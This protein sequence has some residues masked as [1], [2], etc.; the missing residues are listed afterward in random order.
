M[1]ARITHPNL[2]KVYSAGHDAGW[3]YLAMELVDGS[4]VSEMLAARKRFDER[5]ALEVTLGVARA[6][7][8]AERHAI[9]HR[10]VKPANILLKA[11][12]T[13]KLTDLGLAKDRSADPA[14]GLTTVGFCV[15]TTDYL[16][17]E[18][19]GLEGWGTWEPD[20]RGDVF[21]LGLTLYEMLTGE[22]PLKAP[23]P[24]KTLLRHSEEDVPPPS[25]E[26]EE[27]APTTDEIVL[28]M[29]ARHPPERYQS[30][31]E[32]VADLEAVLQRNEPPRIARQRLAWRA[33]R[34]A[35]GEPPP[36]P[37]A[38]VRTIEIVEPVAAAGASAGPPWL[39]I[40]IGA[41]LASLVVAGIAYALLQSG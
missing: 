29:T 30:C 31:A 13:P 5:Q 11:D 18:L 24:T 39:V 32:L 10:D 6:L 41:A 1:S 27:L 35:R 8:E 17:P 21:G 7:A 40:A 4:S 33:E 25:E 2:V 14:S 26:G 38:E 36:G 19:S 22:L 16:S 12:G 9:V 20:A 34:E 37:D 3:H 28:A 15:G 23:T